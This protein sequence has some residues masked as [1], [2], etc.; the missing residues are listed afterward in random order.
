MCIVLDVWLVLMKVSDLFGI[1]WCLVDIKILKIDLGEDVE[2]DFY[3]N[4]EKFICS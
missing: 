2:E 1:F 3:I 4:G